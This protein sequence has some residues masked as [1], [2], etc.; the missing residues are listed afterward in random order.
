MLANVVQILVLALLLDVVISWGEC[1]GGKR[2]SHLPWARNLRKV[3][4]PML[5]PFRNLIPP[6][7][8]RGIDLSPMI[9]ILLLQIIQQMLTR[10]G[11]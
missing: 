2:L 5:S 11:L 8:L 3:T 6:H 4:D 9:A 1:F 10:A 7:K